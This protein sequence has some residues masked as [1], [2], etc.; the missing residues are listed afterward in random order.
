[1]SVSAIATTSLRV[2]LTAVG[3]FIAYTGVDNAFGGIASL[4]FQAAPDFFTVT[5]NEAFAVRDSNVRFLGGLWIGVGLLFVAGAIWLR[6]LKLV[7]CSAIALVFAGGLARFTTMDMGPMFGGALMGSLV[8][9]L[10]L[11]PLLLVWTL[12]TVPVRA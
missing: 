6:A 9:E 11:M 3:L 1:M 2:I 5:D 10:V 7:V 8:A 4:G 12:R